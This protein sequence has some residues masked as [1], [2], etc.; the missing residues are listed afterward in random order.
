MTALGL[1]AA[2]DL[3]MRIAAGEAGARGEPAGAEPMI[4]A[5]VVGLNML[6]EDLEH[7]RAR[8]AVAEALLQDEHDAYDA[9]PALLCSVDATTLRLVKCNATLAAALGVPR[10][11]LVGRVLAEL[12]VEA[13]RLAAAR[14][15][16]AAARGETAAIPELGLARAGGGDLRVSTSVSWS[17]SP[18]PRLRVVWRDVTHERRL[19]AQ[20]LHAQKMQA[21]GRLSGGV[22]HDFNN[23]LAVILASA[24]LARRR[25]APGHA[26][27]PDLAIV[28]E[29]ARRGAALTGQLLAFSRQQVVSPVAVEVGAHVRDVDRML[30]RLIPE[31]IEFALEVAAGEQVA[32]IDP[33]QLT[34]VLINLV[35]NA[36]DAV[37]GEG[38]ITVEVAS[39]D[40]GG[41]ADVVP[42]LD[43]APGGYVLCTV[44]DTGH[45]MSK[46]VQAQV[47][48][49]F[50]TTKP[51]GEGTGLG[52]S[53]C[54]GIVRQAG[55]HI[56]VYSAVG[57][58][59]TV[60]VYLPRHGGA[61][62]AAPAAEAVTVAGAGT[63]RATASHGTETVLCVEDDDTLR[64]LTASVL[65]HAGYRVLVAGDGAEA[66]ASLRARG[67][68]VDLV[69]TDVVMPRMSGRELVEVLRAEGRARAVLF[70]SGY[71]AS[72]VAHGGG[73]GDE[74]E[75]LS[76]PFTPDELLRAVRDAIARGR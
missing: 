22:A 63:A 66:L 44:S 20:L 32:F 56:H 71:T 17:P 8:R 58:G 21:V 70:L 9:S 68:S 35:V 65:E 47:F 12:F 38:R 19:E 74:V 57:V 59:T 40:V 11:Q 16:A 23:I 76:K 61:S 43:L 39:V 14:A 73:L 18:T 37:A 53:V 69:I 26:L 42:A 49:P 48:E 2:L 27:I 50:F 3:L 28:E 33:S 75:F 15:F 34:Q 46:E 36:R 72:A 7:E 64:R 60:K 54:Y 62:V 31:S 4:D 5:I 13:D 25:L 1:D 67:G 52:L 41:A 51:V 45:G 10:E 6:A 29:A 30:R 24:T 55:G